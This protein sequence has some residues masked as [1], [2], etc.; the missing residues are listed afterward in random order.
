MAVD[1]D[2]RSE[3]EGAVMLVRVPTLVLDQKWHRLFALAGKPQEVVDLEAELNDLLLSQGRINERIKEL[4]RKKQKLMSSVVVN[5]DGAQ[6]G[7]ESRTRRLDEDKAEIESIN[8]ELDEL[9]D[10]LLELP[11]KIKQLNNQ[12]MVETMDFCYHKM[13]SNTAEAKEIGEWIL[14][15]R[16]ELKK[17]IIR[18][19]NRDI[20]NRQMYNYMHD[21]FGPEVMDIFDLV[22]GEI[23]MEAINN[24]PKQNTPEKASDGSVKQTASTQGDKRGRVDIKSD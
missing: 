10:E 2:H 8:S 24:P 4:K 13:R 18:K 1:E 17:N 16:V 15:M 7:N 23:D 9:N 20:N 22:S 21:I 19:Q 14:N 12:L 3:F 5:M 6:D 11:M